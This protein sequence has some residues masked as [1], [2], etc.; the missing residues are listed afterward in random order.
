MRL[1]TLLTYFRRRRKEK[2]YR[3]WIEQAGL[4]P[5]ALP[6]LTDE[7]EDMR[8]QPDDREAI[9]PVP[10]SRPTIRFRADSRIA[11]HPKVAGNMMAEI[12]KD[13]L[14]LPLV[15]LLFGVSLLILCVGLILLIVHSC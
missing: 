14:R 11:T 1:T 5:E 8:P 4:P 12:E 2:L 9:S 15:Y 13:R 6:P 10:G 7:S 3:Q